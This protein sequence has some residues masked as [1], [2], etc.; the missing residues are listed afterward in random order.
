[1]HHRKYPQRM[2]THCPV[3]I[4][5][6]L[7]MLGLS[8]TGAA[9]AE[10]ADGNKGESAR[11]SPLVNG[12]AAV[13]GAQPWMVGL[14]RTMRV[15]RPFSELAF[16]GGTLIAPDWV[17]TAAHCV[18]TELPERMLAII[19]RDDL[20]AEGGVV[21]EVQEIIVHPDFGQHGD[22]GDLALLRLT[23]ASTAAVLP[24]LNPA[25]LAALYGTQ[26]SVFGWGNT[27]D[28]DSMDC[29]LIFDDGGS[30]LSGFRCHTV[31]TQ[32]L[33]NPLSLQQ[34]SQRLRTLGECQQRIARI[35]LEAG[36]QAPQPG[37]D[38]YL[39][40]ADRSLCLWQDDDAATVCFG[41]SGGPLVAQVNGKPMLAGIVNS[42]RAG[43]GLELSYVLYADVSQYH[44]FISRSMTRNPARGFDSLCPAQV[45]LEQAVYAAPD[46]VSGMRRA[47]LNWGAAANAE[48]YRLWFTPSDSAAAMVGQ[49]ELPASVT[50]YSAELQAGDNYL[51]A[52]Q[53]A[54][55]ECDGFR[56]SSVRLSV[57]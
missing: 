52:V 8:T 48:Y 4:A 37:E 56:S 12:S 46:P 11:A 16:C 19:G 1:M 50:S 57:P 51:V 30:N 2:Y 31:A 40:A 3:N 15:D 10:T 20:N 18:D 21:H 13:A 24:L 53:A 5:V 41:D 7:A 23:E 42:G 39:D 6:M 9:L 33:N 55:S 25:Q 38:K 27:F 26:L 17:I 28:N 14:V 54:S 44:D 43:C 45:V 29:E 32:T 47:T 34:I 49:L 22:A 36:Q 35:Y